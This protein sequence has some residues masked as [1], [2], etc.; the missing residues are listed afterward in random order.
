MMSIV[1]CVCTYVRKPATTTTA[2][3]NVSP[4]L[5]LQ[6][7]HQQMKFWSYRKLFQPVQMTNN[8]IQ[9][10]YNRKK[11]SS[12][13][14]TGNVIYSFYRAP[15][16]TQLIKFNRRFN[17]TTHSIYSVFD[18]IRLIIEFIPTTRIFILYNFFWR[19]SHFVSRW[20]KNIWLHWDLHFDTFEERIRL[21]KYIYI[22][23]CF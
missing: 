3:F 13:I 17:C 20:K 1:R 16:M 4:C 9:C 15:E 7:R 18:L 8:S 11:N 22:F 6:L 21:E 2:L 23:N 14:S 10:G 12:Q 5:T 19:A